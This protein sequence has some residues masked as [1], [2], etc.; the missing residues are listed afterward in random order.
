MAHLDVQRITYSLPDGRPLLGEVT[1]R[2]GEGVTAALIGPNG[3][4]KTTL[5]RM[6]AGDI[7]PED[8]AITRSGGLGVMRQFI[9]QQSEGTVRDLLLSISPEPLRKVAAEVD[10]AEL[11]LMDSNE[12]KVQMR[13]A[14]ALADFADIG[15]YDAEVLWD[16]CWAMFWEVFWAV[17]WDVSWEV[18][19][20]IFWDVFWDVLWEVLWEMCW[21]MSWD[22]FLGCVLGCVFG[23]V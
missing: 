22:V 11:A 9:G 23:N 13:Y 3:V 1:F 19:W 10:A 17:S 6:I 2:V 12:E 18:F 5:L 21:E 8:G 4:G 20:D 15:G 16:V 14:Q 7:D